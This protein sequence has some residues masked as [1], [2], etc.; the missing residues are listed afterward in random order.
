[1]PNRAE[2][3]DSSAGGGR[4][5]EQRRRDHIWELSEPVNFCQSRLPDASWTPPSSG[6]QIS[7]TDVGLRE[8][9]DV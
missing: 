9:A 6:A 8:C 3:E 7:T 5:S 1:M 2:I 4:Q